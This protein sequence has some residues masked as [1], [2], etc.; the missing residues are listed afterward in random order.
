[1]DYNAPLIA[2]PPSYGALRCDNFPKN[3]PIG[4]LFAATI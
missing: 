3:D 4:V 1:M 2:I